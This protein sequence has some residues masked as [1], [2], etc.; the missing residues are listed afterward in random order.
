[1][2]WVINDG[3]SFYFHN[4]VQKLIFTVWLRTGVPVAF[5]ISYIPTMLHLTV[6]FFY[7]LGSVYK[8]IFN[9]GNPRFLLSF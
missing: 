4:S 7:Y 6:I 2:L 1:M 9:N 5:Q 8:H 3:L